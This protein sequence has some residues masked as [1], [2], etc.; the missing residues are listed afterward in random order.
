VD[1]LPKPDA[2][3]HVLAPLEV[4]DRRVRERGIWRHSRRLSGRQLV[5]YMAE[6]EH[7]VQAAVAR[8]RGL[9][10]TIIEIENGDTAAT[11]D[12][13]ARRLARASALDAPASTG[14][15][16]ARLR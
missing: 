16:Q 1:L 6:A 11:V 3:V 2:V 8:A 10:W 15:A 9:G 7:V 5:R 12:L 14:R 13:A 4:C